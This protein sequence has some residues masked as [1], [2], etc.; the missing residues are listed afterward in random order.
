MIQVKRQSPFFEA[1]KKKSYKENNKK[2]TKVSTTHKTAEKRSENRPISPN[3]AADLEQSLKSKMDV[4]K[5]RGVI[6]DIRVSESKSG[7]SLIVTIL[8]EGEIVSFGT[9]TVDLSGVDNAAKWK[10]KKK[11]VYGNVNGLT[12]RVNP[13]FSHKL[14]E[15]GNAV[16]QSWRQ[17]HVFSDE[18]R[19]ALYSEGARELLGARSAETLRFL[20]GK[21]QPGSM[22][23]TFTANAMEAEWKSHPYKAICDLKTGKITFSLSRADSLY[24]RF[25][26]AM[27]EIRVLE[28]ISAYLKEKEIPATVSY[29]GEPGS[30]QLAFPFELS[31][32]TETV[33]VE[34]SYKRIVLGAYRN[35][36]EKAEQKEKE[37]ENLLKTC[38]YF[39]TYIAQA[40]MTTIE[41]NGNRLTKAQLVNLLRGVNISDDYVIGEYAGKYNLIPKAELAE[42]MEVLTQFGVLRERRVHGEYQDYYVYHVTARG[43]LLA[44]MQNA[45]APKKNPVTEQEYHLVLKAVREDIPMLS[46]REKQR[47][48]KAIVEKP[49]LFLTDPALILDCVERMGEPAAVYLSSFFKEKGDRN[50]R[51]ILKLLLNAASGKGK[52]LPKNGADTFRERRE[53]KRREKEEAQRRDRRL[54]DLVLTM[55][56]KSSCGR[57]PESIWHRCAFWLMSSMRG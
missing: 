52:E 44:R 15:E 20:A 57:K 26:R 12:P 27:K 25:S 14:R 33:A 2:N 35:A 17:A 45:P 10:R 54:F 40:A 6:R 13:A 53:Q 43:K 24:E 29:A 56:L 19:D 46:G 23:T 5:F 42:I 9:L 4:M 47:L 3:P 36:R 49:G 37:T 34:K 32:E 30:F 31:T 41:E 48:L 7:R 16:L 28:E 55:P 11:T 38:P 8:P 51:K 18:M 22:H 39:G 50:N 1:M 21:E